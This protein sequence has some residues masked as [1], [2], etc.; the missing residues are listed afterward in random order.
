MSAMEMGVKNSTSVLSRLM[1]DMEGSKNSTSVF[2]KLMSAMEIGSMN[3]ASANV[4]LE[5][6]TSPS[7]DNLLYAARA[8]G[9][10]INSI[11]NSV[12][13]NKLYISKQKFRIFS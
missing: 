2:S 5:H 11:V 1:S 6:H 7:T 12:K 10:T 4:R 13:C 3:A 8:A 9:E